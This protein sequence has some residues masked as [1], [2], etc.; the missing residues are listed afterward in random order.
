MPRVDTLP[1][2][3]RRRAWPGPDNAVLIRLGM[4]A[5]E[6]EAAGAEVVVQVST[7]CV[8]SLLITHHGRPGRQQA[9]HRIGAPQSGY[10]PHMR[11]GAPA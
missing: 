2:F 8:P 4:D 7:L 9:R 11:G 3:S 10:V 1:G 6:D 5:A